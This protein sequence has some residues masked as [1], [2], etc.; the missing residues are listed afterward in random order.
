MSELR[1]QRVSFSGDAMNVEFSDA[2]S[3]SVPVGSFPR[4]SGATSAERE[5]WQ[6]IGRGLGIHWEAVDED[7]SVENILLAYS[8]TKKEEYAR[9]AGA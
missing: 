5:Q 2:R 1:I 6:L 3:V 9:A 8:R 7:L 4:L